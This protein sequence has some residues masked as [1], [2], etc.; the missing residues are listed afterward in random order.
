MFFWRSG[1]LYFCAASCL[2]PAIFAQQPATYYV[3]P[4]GG[5]GKQCNGIADAAYPGHGSNAACAWSN[6]AFALKNPREWKISGGD[7]ILI[8]PGSYRMGLGG[9][10]TGWNIFDSA[11]SGDAHLPPLPSG[12]DPSRPTILA[13]SGYDQGCQRKAELWGSRNIS[14]VV[15]LS[16]T[17]NALVACLEITDHA[18]CGVGHPDL[19]CTDE[20]DAADAGIYAKGDHGHDVIL[21]DLWIHG[22]AGAGIAGHFGSVT[23]DRVTISGNGMSG[24]DADVKTRGTFSPKVVITHSTIEWNGCVEDAASHLPAAHGCSGESAGG[25]GDG[26]GADD[27]G[28]SWTV[29]QSTFRY[30][31]QDGLDLLYVKQPGATVVIDG[32]TAY[33]NSGNQVK[34]S[35]RALVM[36]S[37][38][39]G[40]CSFF[41]GK[42]FSALKGYFSEDAKEYHQGDLCRANGDALVVTVQNGTQSRILN[43]TI[44]GEGD[45]L[46]W[47]LCQN[48]ED[49]PCD[50]S[51]EVEIA[52]NVLRGFPRKGEFRDKKLGRNGSLVGSILAENGVVRKVR[53]NLFFNLDKAYGDFHAQ[54]PLGPG[55]VCADPHFAKD[56]LSEAF[57]GR[58][59]DDSPA[60]GAG[61]PLSQVT[62]DHDQ[63]P[64]PAGQPYD[65]G[66]FQGKHD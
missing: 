41:D 25:Y 28:G 17:S 54:C 31:T 60:R 59:T 13:G 32:V 64:R 3:R 2:G 43:N 19:R 23:L 51:S 39:I 40:N 49:G 11:Q 14:M 57:D 8:A 16:E 6:P 65:L 44:V 62:R 63:S 58:L 27:Q 52:N 36:N 12:P 35:G 9:K 22:V 47:A 42:P 48:R 10:N 61:A 34:V 56:V 55:D 20:S 7:R 37:V 33:G 50:A 38:I 46:V 45:F 66:A 29:S 24:W 30:N 1:L 18:T 21:R 26:I 53:Q 4:D 15:N 5:T